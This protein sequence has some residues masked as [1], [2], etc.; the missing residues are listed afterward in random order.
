M[1]NIDNKI[2]IFLIALNYSILI[3]DYIYNA[4]LNYCHLQRYLFLL[5]YYQIW[6]TLLNFMYWKIAIWFEYCWISQNRNELLEVFLMS[7]SC[8]KMKKINLNYLVRNEIYKQY[9]RMKLS[10][11]WKKIVFRRNISLM[12][13][14]CDRNYSLHHVFAYD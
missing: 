14:V 5:K 1:I 7:F 6:Y 4:Y 2:L 11:K 12:N 8:K 13:S 10:V 9:L 3:S